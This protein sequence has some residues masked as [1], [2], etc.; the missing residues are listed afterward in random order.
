[1]DSGLGPLGT[2][3]AAAWNWE[4]LFV[5]LLLWVLSALGFGSNLALDFDFWFLV[6]AHEEEEEEK[7]EKLE[8]CSDWWAERWE[9][10]KL[11]IPITSSQGS[12]T[13]W[14]FAAIEIDGIII[15]MIILILD[16]EKMHIPTPP[17]SNQRSQ[18]PSNT[19]ILLT[20]KWMMR[21]EEE[22][23]GYINRL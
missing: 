11:R 2:L 5:E 17:V 13:A 4:L 12:T 15:I 6:V 23:E 18:Y 10:S 8:V 22:R 9:K 16:V 3:W 21:E 14:D 1:M 7:S 19:Q 20:V